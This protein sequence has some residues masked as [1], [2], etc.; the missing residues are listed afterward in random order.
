MET[1]HATSGIRRIAII[2]P[3]CTGKTTLSQ[4]LAEHFNAEWIPEYARQYITELEGKYA[5]D[6][7]VFIAKKQID[8]FDFSDDS[9][10]NQIFFDTN[11]IITK[12]WFDVAFDECPDWVED[13][14][15]T[16]KFDYHLLCNT[17][18][19]WEPDIV[20][21][22]GGKKRERLFN[23][24]EQEL[25]KRG[26]PYGIVAGDGDSRLTNALTLLNSFFNDTT[27]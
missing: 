5:M 2:G 21:E 6:D 19:P 12:V 17:E 3:E 4:Q 24:Y 8:E 18:L 10:Y 15:V 23:I 26:F 25:K 13:A 27:T 1:Q 22:N 20:R 11:L 7:V 16:R 9:A 14:I